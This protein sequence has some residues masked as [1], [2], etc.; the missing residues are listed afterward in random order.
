MKTTWIF[1]LLSSFLLEVSAAQNFSIEGLSAEQAGL[2]IARE[3]D[4]RDLGF[5][6][7]TA[8]MTMT[9]SNRKGATSVRHIRNRTLEING[10]GDQSL[11][12]FEE[13]ADVKGTVSMTYSHG[14]QPDDQWIYMP[15]VKRVKRIN[16][17]NKSGPFMGSE[18][19]FEDIGSQEVEKYTYKYLREEPLAGIACYVVER[20][21]AYEFSGYVRQI[22]WLDKA[23]FRAQ[24]IDFYDRKNALLKTL[25]FTGY[26]QYL[27]KHW[28][29]DKMSVINHQT[30]KST[31]LE[32]KNFKFKTGLTGRDFDQAALRST[33]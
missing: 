30:G 18:F 1:V 12:I 20:V 11:S 6:D 22:V 2:A 28:R 4:R 19:A 17:K 16:S 32:W 14:L 8:E 15:A 5:G 13:P 24:K 29:A 9:L 25:T 10:D 7:F 27:G 21:P 23:E 31:V 33:N 3:I 26:Q